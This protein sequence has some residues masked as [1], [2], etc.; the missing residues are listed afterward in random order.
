MSDNPT[1][2]KR[3]YGGRKPILDA[4]LVSA[5]IVSY[6]G[7]I[8]AVAKQ[9]GV[10]RTSIIELIDKRPSL[11]KV[12]KDAREGILDIAESALLSA[13]LDRQPWA[14]CFLLKTQGKHRGYSEKHVVAA[15]K[16]Q[17]TINIIQEFTG[18]QQPPAQQITHTDGPQNA[19]A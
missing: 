13:V 14:I 7:N 8:T 16:E 12:L 10:S 9:F 3:R 6:H 2:K 19:A 5:S 17:P 11:Q 18:Q 15:E 1:P 4:E